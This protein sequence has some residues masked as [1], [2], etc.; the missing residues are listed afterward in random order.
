MLVNV[1]FTNLTNPPIVVQ[2]LADEQ[3]LNECCEIFDPVGFLGFPQDWYDTARNA[4]IGRMAWLA[5]NPSV[6]FANEKIKTTDITL[7]TGLS[8][9][10]SS[11]SPVLSLPKGLKIISQPGIEVNSPYAPPRLL[12][13]MVTDTMAASVKLPSV[14]S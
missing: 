10:G 12:G 3:F 5:S 11:G 2:E 9:G 8:F 4:P 13:I 7:V 1:A 6:S 14:I